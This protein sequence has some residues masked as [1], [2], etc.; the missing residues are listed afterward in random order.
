MTYSETTSSKRGNMTTEHS[1]DDSYWTESGDTTEQKRLRR[2]QSWWRETELQVPA[3]HIKTRDKPV[4]SMLPEEA[5]G[6]LNL[7]TLEARQAFARADDRLKAAPG[8]GI[9]EPTRLWR[10]L[11]SSQPLCFNLF[12]YLA[13]DPSAL[14]P[15]VQSWAPDATAVMDIELEWAPTE[16]ALARSAFD[17]LV[18]YAVGHG[19]RG[20]L[21]IECKY[22]E[23]L[24]QAQRNAAAEKFVQAT[25]NG[26]WKSG[27]AEALDQN[28]LRQFWYNTLL[29]QQVL[30][31]GDY[32]AGRSLV[33][34]LDGDTKAK[35]AV[36]QVACHLRDPEFL[37][38]DSLE[39]VVGSVA[40][41]DEW[42]KTFE[43][44]YLRL[45]VS[46]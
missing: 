4:A 28:G 10:N 42:A 9:I 15:W 44:R 20:F 25:Q 35:H 8:A 12:G 46:A 17:A 6:D 7:W 37:V 43:R 27:A 2:H 30:R 45:D 31:D 33:V 29:A 36:T 26:A 21:G 11:L 16:G 32:V 13:A 23:D 41:H 5:S 39:R 38:F 34:A 24:M 3:G 14:L 19:Q 40:G 22:A 18:T 1:W